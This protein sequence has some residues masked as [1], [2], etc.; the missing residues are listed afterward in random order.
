MHWAITCLTSLLSEA[1]KDDGTCLG[2]DRGPFPKAPD[3]TLDRVLS[4]VGDRSQHLIEKKNLIR[5][6]CFVIDGVD[7]IAKENP[8]A[9]RHLVTTAK[10]LVILVSSEGHVMPFIDSSSVANRSDGV[11]EILDLTDEVVKDFLMQYPEEKKSPS[12]ECAK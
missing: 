8:C 9:F 4:V 7:L 12:M 5:M 3:E 10:L 11:V 6:L 1:I 2:I